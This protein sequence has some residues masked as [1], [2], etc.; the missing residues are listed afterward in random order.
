MGGQTHSPE[1]C[2]DSPKHPERTIHENDGVPTRINTINL[3]RINSL[4]MTSDDSGTEE[5]LSPDQ[6]QVRLTTTPTSDTVDLRTCLG[7]LLT[8]AQNYCGAIQQ[9][10]LLTLAWLLYNYLGDVG[11]T[12]SIVLFLAYQSTL[13]LS[14]ARPNP[15]I[16]KLN[17][18]SHNT[19]PVSSKDPDLTKT[20]YDS[21]QIPQKNKLLLKQKILAFRNKRSKVHQHQLSE[22]EESLLIEEPVEL[23]SYPSDVPLH[24]KFVLKGSV[25]EVPVV[26][27]VDTGSCI[28]LISDD[29]FEK[30]P[31]NGLLHKIPLHVTY[32]DFQGQTVKALGKYLL[33]LHLGE[34]VH[35]TQEVI[36]V[37]HPDKSQPHALIG[38]DLVRAKRLDIDTMGNS[39]AYLSFLVGEATKRIELQTTQDCFV[40]Q[41]HEIDGGESGF[42]HVSLLENINKISLQNVSQISN[43]QGVVNCSLGEGYTI[44]T[45]SLCN[46]DNTASFQ[47][48]V[49]NKQFG[50]LTFFKGQKLGTFSPLSPGTLLQ[51]TSNVFETIGS[52]SKSAP[53]LGSS[54]LQLS[55]TLLKIPP[56]KVSFEGKHNK[57]EHA[58]QVLRAKTIKGLN[59]PV[60]VSNNTILLPPISVLP[61]LHSWEKAFQLLKTHEKNSATIT[62]DYSTLPVDSA[63]MIQ[64]AFHEVFQNQPTQLHLVHNELQIHRTK[65]VS[66]DSDSSSAPSEDDLCESIFQPR[67]ISSSADT[68]NSLLKHVPAYLQKTVFH[69][70]TSKYPDVIAKTTVDF[71]KCTLPNSEFKIELHDQTAITCR[72]YP[73]NIV[74]KTFV[75]ET[76]QDMVDAGLLIE[77]ASSYGSGVFVRSR[78][79]GSGQNNYRIRKANKENSF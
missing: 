70:L 27:E 24:S 20:V 9:S 6:E 77:E 46:L 13:Y 72:P 58:Y 47:L 69:M 79:D 76:I 16:N 75:D 22:L 61:E 56:H 36:V 68:W 1:E 44:P 34:K 52:D 37:D 33:T 48:P 63:N 11:I 17:P 45:V 66:E 39:K 38:V 42:V 32:A 15:K 78:P 73:L 50:P 8:H 71:G 67:R 14:N 7:I 43:T 28:C 5:E 53:N 31:N 40:S 23:P 25:N 2:R 12:F 51:T 59:S 26:W 30:I 57:P 4:R 41:T 10:L 74:Y 18:Q 54:I 65:V 64:V 49:K 21:L 55:E 29:I 60:T 19:S 62:I 3:F 35:T